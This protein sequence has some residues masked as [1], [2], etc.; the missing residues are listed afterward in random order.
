MTSATSTPLDA[1]TRMTVTVAWVI[2][3]NKPFYPI[4]V[5]Y[6]VGNGVMASVATLV[7]VP[8]FLAIPLFARRFPLCARTALPLVGTVDT[9]FETKLFGQGSGTEL[10]FA[11]CMMLVALS[12]RPEEK[13]LQRGVAVFVFAAFAFSRNFIGLPLHAWT[14]FDLKILLDLNAFAVASL[15]AFIALNSA[16]IGKDPEIR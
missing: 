15:M 3:M 10:F 13:W 1:R 8:F 6:L 2:V 16:G 14:E 11:A 7:S 12:F 5:W 4:Y 9:L